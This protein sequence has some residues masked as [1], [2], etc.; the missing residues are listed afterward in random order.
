MCISRYDKLKPYGICIS[1]CIDGWSRKI[2]WLHAAK[3]NKE[4]KLISGYFVDAIQEHDGCPMVGF[5]LCFLT[6][7]GQD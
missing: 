6:K 7:K 4:P 1:G 3:T 2:I 5:S